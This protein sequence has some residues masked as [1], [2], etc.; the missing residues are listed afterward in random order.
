MRHRLR[1]IPAVL[2]VLLMVVFIFLPVAVL[3]QYSFQDGMLPVPPFKGFSLRWYDKVFVNERLIAALW[4]SVLVGGLSSL[5]ATALG[6]LA[7]Y[8]LARK[9]PR[10]AGAMQFGL[11]APITVSYLIIGMG[12]QIVSNQLGLEKSLLLV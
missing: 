7:A 6:F 2:Y 9:R 3:V 8:G 11:M 5:M 1:Q 4:N 12:L 10:A